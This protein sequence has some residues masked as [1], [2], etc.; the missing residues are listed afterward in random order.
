M[1]RRSRM[2]RPW[3]LVSLL[4]MTK[5][6]IGLLQ[7]GGRAAILPL[8]PKQLFF[9]SAHH[10][11]L[12]LLLS[13][14]G[15][16]SRPKSCNSGASF[17]SWVYLNCELW[18]CLFCHPYPLIYM[19]HHGKPPVRLSLSGDLLWW[20]CSLS[21]QITVNLSSTSLLLSFSIVITKCLIF[22]CLRSIQKHR[23]SPIR[24]FGIFNLVLSVPLSRL[25]H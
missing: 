2:C 6:L 25:S 24:I 19:S 23:S 20:I 17:Q 1:R 12:L 14:L 7:V 9:L 21:P 3:R 13:L 4:L 15:E 5:S 16:P 10:D 8:L 18:W 11:N 22:H